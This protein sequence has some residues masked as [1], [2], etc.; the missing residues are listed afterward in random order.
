VTPPIVVAILFGILWKR[1]TPAASFATMIGGGALVGISFI[2]GLD[3]RLVGPFSFGMGPDSYNYTRA[4]FGLAACGLVGFVVTLF[5]KPRAESDIMGLV[6]GTQLQAMKAYKGGEINRRLGQKV[7][8]RLRIDPSL[9]DS[10]CMVPAHAMANMAADS[11]DLLYVADARWWFGGLRSVHVTA[12][13]AHEGAEVH[14]NAAAARDA[15]LHNGQEVIVEK[16][17]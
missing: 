17:F 13:D 1:F 3:E 12:G 14:M 9:A 10:M 15:H 4:L 6:T 2:P 11:G 7:R 16:L 5:S 8:L